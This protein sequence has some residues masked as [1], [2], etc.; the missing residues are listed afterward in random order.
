MNVIFDSINEID[1]VRWV[2][3]VYHVRALGISIFAFKVSR[4][5]FSFHEIF[6]FYLPFIQII[7]SLN[8]IHDISGNKFDISHDSLNDITLKFRL[9]KYVIFHKIQ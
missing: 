8:I 1:L 9:K 6:M 5:E 2:T 3:D 4:C 7:I